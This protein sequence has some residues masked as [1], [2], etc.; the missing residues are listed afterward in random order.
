MV[1]RGTLKFK[2]ILSAV[3]SA[4]ML[5]STNLSAFAEQVETFE[6]TDLV[7]IQAD[8][9]EDAGML[10]KAKL[11]N[12][13]QGGYLALKNDK[14]MT[15]FYDHFEEAGLQMVRFGHL[16]N[17]QFY[18]AVTRGENGAL[19]FDFSRL[20]A[21]ILPLLDKGIKPFMIVSYMPSAL[22]NNAPDNRQLPQNLEEWE[23]CVEAL[24]QHY[25]DL[26]HTGWYWEVW[27]EPN[28]KG[29]WNDTPENYVTLYEH[30]AN[31]VK[32]ADPTAKVGGSGEAYATGHVLD[33]LLTH[34]GQHPEVPMDF[35]SWHHYGTDSF[36]SVNVINDLLE[37]NNLGE[38]ELLITEWNFTTDM[39]SGAGGLVDTNAGAAYMAKRMYNSL[40]YTDL[41]KIFFFT[42]AEGWSPNAV[43]NGDLGLLTINNHKKATYHTMKMY[44]QL[45]NELVAADI[46][47]EPTTDKDTYAIVT[48]DDASGKVSMMVWNYNNRETEVNLNL[49]NLPYLDE[50]KQFKVSQY[51]IDETHSNFYKDIQRGIY[52]AEQGPT[53]ELALVSSYIEA[54][55]QTWSEELYMS[56]NSV[57]QLILEPTDL[58]PVKQLPIPMAPLPA[59][60]LAAGKNVVYSS[61]Q[62]GAG[63]SAGRINDGSRHSFPDANEGGPSLGW[64]SSIADQAEQEEWV[65]IDLGEQQTFHTVKLYP[66][67]YRDQK[68]KGFPNS[69]T[70]QGSNSMEG[71][72]E[73]LSVQTNFNNGLPVEDAQTF[74]FEEVSY[75]YVRVV[76]NELSMLTSTTVP[77]I[78]KSVTASSSVENYG[79]FK[80]DVNDGDLL[81]KG[82]HS[83][84]GVKNQNTPQWVSIDLSSVVG[85]DEILIHPA[86]KQSNGNTRFPPRFKVEISDTPDFSNS[87]TVIDSTYSDY[88]APNGQVLT[89]NVDDEGRYVRFYA[90]KLTNVGGTDFG[91]ALKEIT[92]HSAAPVGQYGLQLSE[93]EIYGDAGTAPTSP[94]QL[95]ATTADNQVSLMWEDRSGNEVGFEVE[96][97]QV[98]KHTWTVLGNVP[99]GTTSYIDSDSF[100]NRLYEY[101]VKAY[102]HYGLSDGALT[103]YP[104]FK[105]TV[106]KLASYGKSVSA[107]SSVESWGWSKDG[108]VDGIK[109][110]T[111]YHSKQGVTDQ[112]TTQWAVIDL[113]EQED[114]TKIIMYPSKIQANGQY[115]FP[116]RFRIDVSNDPE[117]GTYTTVVDQSQEDYVDPQDQPVTFDVQGQGRYVR[118]YS[119]KLAPVQDQGKTVYVLTLAELEVYSSTP[120]VDGI[121]FTEEEQSVAV[122]QS[123]P[124]QVQVTPDF[125][126]YKGVTWSSQDE[127]IAVVTTAV[128]GSNEAL[129]RGVKEGTTTITATT[130]DGGYQDEIIIHVTAPP[131]IPDNNGESGGTGTG[132][133]TGTV[134][135]TEVRDGVADVSA[136]A[137][138]SEGEDDDGNI[139]TYASLSQQQIDALLKQPGIQALA[140]GYEGNSN[141][142]SW[143]L[144]LQSIEQLQAGNIRLMISVD[145]VQL[146][147]PSQVLDMAMLK[148]QI[149][150]L[151]ANMTV[152]LKVSAVEAE[153]SAEMTGKLGSDQKPIGSVWSF[154]IEV[155]AGGDRVLTISEF[156]DAQVKGVIGYN[157]DDIQDV[158][159]ARKLNVYKYNEQSGAWEPRR[160]VSL[161]SQHSVTFYTNTFSYYTIAET[162]R[163]FEDV[164]GH[165]GQEEIELL[166]SKHIVS[167]MSEQ[168][169][170]PE[171]QLTRAQFAQMLVQALGITLH[172]PTHSFA[173]VPTGS[174]YEYSVRT[175]AEAGI[176]TG[177][178]NNRFDPN[179]RITRE[180]MAV[181]L[182]R[183]YRYQM[184][185]AATS[186]SGDMKVAFDDDQDIQDWAIEDVLTTVKL[187]LLKG[188]SATEFNPQGLAS[189]AQA[190]TAVVRLLQQTE[191]L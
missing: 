104:L 132:T 130:I 172:T 33:T 44:S 179:A 149:G 12:A 118:L 135:E 66:I 45:E 2:V 1:T 16:L 93:I 125:A 88:P 115:R 5:M 181:M 134:V 8:Y 120:G 23:Q 70:I 170:M 48:K 119:D 103:A 142:L 154:G 150:E 84:L 27:N 152:T 42:P 145:N 106:V 175:A 166:A 68:G 171:E 78:G 158:A 9:N 148:K 191:Q 77:S 86:D 164:I 97:K 7:T 74:S 46:S 15:G 101:R 186:G 35:V 11:L 71:P 85:I 163:S 109:T 100:D 81:D 173:D 20:D 40:E 56:P 160:S 60:N 107:S 24:V 92:V 31:A 64:R 34:L 50:G 146:E 144:P 65:G 19:S 41:D 21:N 59:V 131:T 112:N 124:L 52:G 139:M 122:G 47:G 133:G 63:W 43:F 156:G 159:D 32:A 178:G 51:L 6:N 153:Q 73:N 91:F 17:D 69:F 28:Y 185:E 184:D 95:Q 67:D 29:F 36:E 4:C 25:A 105:K 161:T 108:L 39:A 137:Q 62:E 79:W 38:K 128:Y 169:F 3:L 126:A 110:G 87:I 49:D 75:Q 14:W 117:F 13:S 167:G 89:L 143:Q 176:V 57:I 83:A 189:R 136:M 187:G 37:E 80:N 111:G 22:M 98:G 10:D 123:A 183:A 141:N 76:A 168:L 55:S 58:P 113:E 129:V 102:N 151:N 180:Q 30:T 18:H 114:V 54:S 96:R 138:F 82:Y 147:V 61:S 155:N 72:W 121:A 116:V 157:P 90:T 99:A 190:A 174:W 177:V 94:A 140:V 188:M 53:E 182:M 165:W 162:N 127:S 26:G